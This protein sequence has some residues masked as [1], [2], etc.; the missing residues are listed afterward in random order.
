MI[1]MFFG[2]FFVPLGIIISFSILIFIRIKFQSNF[3]EHH[4]KQ[5]AKLENLRNLNNKSDDCVNLKLN[6]LN[7]QCERN[8]VNKL[9]S[10][11]MKRRSLCS[12]DTDAPILRKEDFNFKL[13][14]TRNQIANSNLSIYLSK[15]GKQLH[16]YQ[17]AREMRNDYKEKKSV[18][19]NNDS[20]K[21]KKL[22]DDATS[23][24]IDENPRNLIERQ[25]LFSSL[26]KRELKLI[27]YIFFVLL[28]YIVA[29]SPYA[30]LTIIAQF[31]TDIENYVTPFTTILTAVFAKTSTVLNPVLYSLNNQHFIEFVRVKI[32]KQKLNRNSKCN[33]SF[34]HSG[35]PR[36]LKHSYSIIRQSDSV[37]KHTINNQN[38]YGVGNQTN[39][40]PKLTTK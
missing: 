37:K 32:F 11:E 18:S 20:L 8:C 15:S 19:F 25:K 2:G 9:R 24:K 12:F 4:Q 38:N 22:A 26:I 27:K 17:S 29:W 36:A 40:S 21:S 39:N 34:I 14:P 31:S 13:S 7:N 23:N 1:F 33:S 35:S 6:N 10:L 16:I 5:L 3:I 30:M 28:F